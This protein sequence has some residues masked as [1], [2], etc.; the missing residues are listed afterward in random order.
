MSEIL[1]ARDSL[2]DSWK[3]RFFSSEERDFVDTHTGEKRRRKYVCSSGDDTP[4]PSQGTSNLLRH[5]RNKHSINVEGEKKIVC[6]VC[7]I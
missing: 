3:S 5:L 7:Y 6:R 2:S 4:C 1:N